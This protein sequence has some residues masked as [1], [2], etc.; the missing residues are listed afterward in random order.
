MVSRKAKIICI[1][2]VVVA[3][4]IA[5]LVVGLYFGLRD[6]GGDEITQEVTITPATTNRCEIIKP[7]E[8]KGNGKFCAC[9]KDPDSDDTLQDDNC[10]NEIRD[11]DGFN[12]CFANICSQAECDGLCEAIL[13][14]SGIFYKL[15]SK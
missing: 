6:T 15:R 3:V 13:N 2:S 4:S 1:V 11:A 14:F 12:W 5:A 7:S 10:L 8:L 9:G